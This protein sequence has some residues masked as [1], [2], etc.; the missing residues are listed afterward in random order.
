M[1]NK[2]YDIA[3]NDS[4]TFY[5]YELY[6]SPENR[7]IINCTEEFLN[8]GFLKDSVWDKYA[9]YSYKCKDCPHFKHDIGFYFGDKLDFV[10]ENGDEDTNTKNEFANTNDVIYVAVNYEGIDTKGNPI[11]YTVLY[12]CELM[13]LPEFQ[14]I[15]ND[16]NCY[17]VDSGDMKRLELAYALTVHKIQ[18]SQAKLIICVMYPIRYSDF[19][20]RNMIYTSITRAV[21]GIYLVGNVLGSGSSITKGRKIEQTSQRLTYNS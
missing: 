4:L 21:E 20:S 13:S 10:D 3:F 7:E 16:E 2:F 9:E 1:N 8:Q 14:K 19:I 5:T 17:I 12:Q 11:T 6:C 18:G 15:Q